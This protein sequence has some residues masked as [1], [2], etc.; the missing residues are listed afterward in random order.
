V[1]SLLPGDMICIRPQGTKRAEYGCLS[2]IYDRLL[3]SRVL[4]M[5]MQKINHKRRGR[6]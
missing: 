1:I 6:K 3:R 4:S 5:Q 2:E